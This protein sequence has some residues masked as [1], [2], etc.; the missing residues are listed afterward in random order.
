MVSSVAAV[1]S[2]EEL[3]DSS[4]FGHFLLLFL[5]PFIAN[6]LSNLFFLPPV[7][8]CFSSLSLSLPPFFLSLCNA[9]I[10]AS[11]SIWVSFSFILSM[12]ILGGISLLSSSQ[13]G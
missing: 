10:A 1:I 9:G 2:I 4:C 13:N 5:L 6:I 7:T 3:L 11:R 12:P 8:Y